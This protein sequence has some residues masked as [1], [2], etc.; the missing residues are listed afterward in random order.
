MLDGIKSFKEK[1]RIRNKTRLIIE[2][3]FIQ[4]LIVIT[5][6]C[7]SSPGCNSEI[8]PNGQVAGGRYDYF[9]MI[10]SLTWRFLQASSTSFF[11]GGNVN[12]HW[13]TCSKISSGCFEQQIAFECDGVAPR[14]LVW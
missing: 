12:T 5:S 14:L 3:G 1:I 4:V 6:I 2:Q 13:A 10:R 8:L 9:M 11:A 7:F